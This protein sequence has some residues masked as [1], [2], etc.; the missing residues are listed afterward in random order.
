MNDQIDVFQPGMVRQLDGELFVRKTATDR[1]D[2]SGIVKILVQREYALET[3]DCLA[4]IFCTNQTCDLLNRIE[5][6]R[7]RQPVHRRGILSRP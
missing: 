7:A 6:A 4:V 2:F 5:L 3:F 1:N